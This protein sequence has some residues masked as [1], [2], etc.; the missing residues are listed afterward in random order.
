MDYDYSGFGDTKVVV[1]VNP[2]KAITVPKGEIGKLRTTE[3]F[4]AC[5]NDKPQG[6]HFDED[7]LSAFD[8]EY[9]S[10]TLQELEEA[11][12][13]KNFSN[14]EVKDKKIVEGVDINKIKDLLKERVKKVS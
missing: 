11:V 13:N 14:F 8:D 6:V 9:Y 4:I 2:S 1:L 12:A 10:F 3:M 7:A 5:T